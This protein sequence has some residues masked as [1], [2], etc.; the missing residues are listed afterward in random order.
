MLAASVPDVDMNGL[1]TLGDQLKDKLG[2]G[3]VVLGSALGGKV[4]LLAW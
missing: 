3:V 4:S 1:R 2:S